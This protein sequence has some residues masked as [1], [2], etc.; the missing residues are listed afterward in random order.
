[1]VP[2]TSTP[3]Q[4]TVAAETHLAEGHF[5]SGRANTEHRKFSDMQNRNSK[6]NSFE[7]RRTE[8]ITVKKNLNN[9]SAPKGIYFT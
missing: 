4:T 7:R 8:F 5:F 6:T 1:L 2:N 3:L 9:D